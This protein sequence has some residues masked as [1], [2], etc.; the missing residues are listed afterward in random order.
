MLGRLNGPA[1]SNIDGHISWKETYIYFSNKNNLIVHIAY[2]LRRTI[3]DRFKCFTIIMNRNWNRN[4]N[5]WAKIK[6]I[7]KE[8]ISHSYVYCEAIDFFFVTNISNQMITKR[9]EERNSFKLEK[10]LDV[11]FFFHCFHWFFISFNWTFQSISCVCVCVWMYAPPPCTAHMR[12]TISR[13]SYCIQK[14]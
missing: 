2:V 4:R 9:T 3:D 13:F 12:F 7:R 5:E 8:I 6:W 1:S 11:L 14:S 10:K